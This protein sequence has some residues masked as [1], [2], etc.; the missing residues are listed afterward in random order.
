MTERHHNATTAFWLIAAFTVIMVTGLAIAGTMYQRQVN[1]SIHDQSY[2]S[3]LERTKLQVEHNDL[4][5]AV[6]VALNDFAASRREL[7][8]TAPPGDAAIMRSTAAR[9]VEL[10]KTIDPITVA[11]CR[12]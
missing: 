2:Y 7:A 4:G 9:L 11:K 10:A 3:C 5:E 1:A 12:R 8:E 6:T